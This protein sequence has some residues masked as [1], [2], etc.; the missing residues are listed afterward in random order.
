MSPVGKKLISDIVRSEARDPSPFIVL[1]PRMQVTNS[2]GLLALTSLG[3]A[4][5]LWLDTEGASLIGTLRKVWNEEEPRLRGMLLISLLHRAQTPGIADP[6]AALES[7]ALGV[8]HLLPALVWY[9]PTCTCG[10]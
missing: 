8:A 7:C 3:S 5:C 10:S 2:L 1:C 6:A 4:P 9:G